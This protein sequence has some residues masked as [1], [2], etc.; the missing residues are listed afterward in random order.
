MISITYKN[1]E[2]VNLEHGV[3]F[4][5]TYYSD[6]EEAIEQFLEMEELESADELSDDIE[7]ELT[8]SIDK[9]VIKFDP[10]WIDFLMEYPM[11]DVP[12]E[13]ADG[14][15]DSTETQIKNA[16]IKNI[17]FDKINEEIPKLYFSD[18]E[19]FLNK[20]QMKALTS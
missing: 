9:P 8:A 13:P 11:D 17:D 14:F 12:I 20:E 6:I 16:I 7:L 1:G 2:E 15:Y 5:D 19:F 18:K 10:K 3:F 4:G